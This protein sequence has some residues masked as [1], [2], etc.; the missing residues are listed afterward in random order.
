[1]SGYRPPARLDCAVTL[2]VP[3]R[4]TALGATTKKWPGDGPVILCSWKT[5]GGTEQTVNGMLMIAD[6]AVMECWY[7]P[8]IVSGCRVR[9]KSGALYEIIG[10]PEDIDQRHQHMRIKLERTKGGA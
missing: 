1:M 5:Y 8:R 7:D 9:L 2:L 3:E 10:E 6:T 4:S